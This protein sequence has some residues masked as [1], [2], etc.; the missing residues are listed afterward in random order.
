MANKILIENGQGILS[1]PIKY[2]SDFYRLLIGF[3]VTAERSEM[4]SFFV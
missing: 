2:H 1:V 3:Y 4:K